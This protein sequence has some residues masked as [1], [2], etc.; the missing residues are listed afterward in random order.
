MST[1]PM[2]PLREFGTWS[3]GNT[4]SKQDLSYW[5]DGSIPWVSPKDM[6]VDEIDSTEDHLSEVAI[7]RGKASLLEPGAV[8]V[9][10]R[11]GILSHTLPVAVRNPACCPSTWHL[12]CVAQ[13][14]AYSECARSMGPRLRRLKRARS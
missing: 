6:K 2:T 11:S 14:S 10:T 13:R 3:G 8:L 4:P 9:V 1:M 7:A 5:T 12:N